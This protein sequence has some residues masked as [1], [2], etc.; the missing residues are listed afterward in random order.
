MNFQILACTISVVAHGN[1]TMARAILRPLKLLF[2]IMARIKPSK[3]DNPTTATVHITVF[4]R[5]MENIGLLNTL[6][7]LSNPQKPL[8][9]PAL[10]ILLRDMR[11]TNPIGVTMKTAIRSTL[12]RI[13]IYGS[14]RRNF[15]FIRMPHFCNVINKNVLDLKKWTEP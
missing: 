12:G 1:T 2:R 8:I 5:T 10:L 7:K 4:F 15:F 14:I 11:N 13:Q 6:W 9:R 3:V